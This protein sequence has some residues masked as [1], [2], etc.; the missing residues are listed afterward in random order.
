MQTVFRAG[1]YA[2]AAADTFG[3]EGD[4]ADGEPHGAGPLAGSAGDAFFLLPMD[5]QCYPMGTPMAHSFSISKI[6]STV[7]G[8]IH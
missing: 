8:L 5:L 1:A 2:S 6:N 7:L 4:L 3:G